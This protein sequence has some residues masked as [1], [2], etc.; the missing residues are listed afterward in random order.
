M[1]AE[2]KISNRLGIGFFVLLLLFCCAVLV[3]I[4]AL[5]TASDGFRDYRS[6]ARNTNNAG[7]VQANLLSLRIAA[8]H[9]INNGKAEALREE[10]ARM[11]ALKALLQSAHQDAISQE[12]IS[13]F[14]EVEQLADQYASTFEKV[15]A[16]ISERNNLVHDNLNVIGPR[17]EKELSQILLNARTDNDMETAFLQPRLC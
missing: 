9:Y 7:R 13:T 1:F 17:M 4:Q 3:S 12:Q 16:K 5:N 10:L 2:L 6:L 8:L 15:A 11:A 14:N